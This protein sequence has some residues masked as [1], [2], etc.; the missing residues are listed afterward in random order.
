MRKRKTTKT[1]VAFYAP[2]KAP[3]HKVAS[4]DRTLARNLLSALRAA[5]CSVELASD[6]RSLD[7]DGRRAAQKKLRARGLAIADR[8][9]TAYM[10]RPASARPQMW[11]TYHLYHKAPDWIGPYVAAFLGIP[12]VVA[13]AS[14][15]P[16][17]AE[18]KWRDGYRAVV[19]TLAR[20]D[21]VISFNSDDVACVRKSIGNATAHVLM[22]P[23]A[24]TS[25][26]RAVHADDARRRIRHRHRIPAGD[27]VL[28]AVGMMR[29]GDKLDSY[30][31]LATSLRKLR[32]P[33][34][35]LLVVGD[36]PAAAKIKRLFRGL[37]ARVGFLGALPHAALA[38]V[39][40]AA[41]LFVWPAMGEAFGM[42]FIEAQAAG[43]PCVAGRSGGVADIV[44]HGVTGRIVPAGN[45][46]AFAR[47]VDRSI[48]DPALR[49][50]QG[51]AAARHAKTHL[52]Q[53][54]AAARLMKILA[55]LPAK[56]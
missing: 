2:L 19:Q 12:Y 17:E 53:T 26:F 38:K 49:R 7:I 55:S 5:G 41:D 51:R 18:G 39:Y 46:A 48:A 45:A 28:L 36:G 40:A 24:E 22:P 14:V 16:R 3:T 54:A 11:F 42:V 44:R 29:D 50:R 52:D 21:A 20:A 1:R 15:V 23:F 30:R 13:E 35:H 37:E 27:T 10:R 47:A 33:D 56:H 9:I 34:W 6:F 43:L 31:V 4:G 25:V 8:L 32:A